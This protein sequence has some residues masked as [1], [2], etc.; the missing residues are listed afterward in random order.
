MTLN[1]IVKIAETA[2]SGQYRHDGVTPYFEHPRSV[3]SLVEGEYAK[4]VAFLHDVIEDTDETE[5]SLLEKGVPK[6]VVDAVVILTKTGEDYFEYLRKVKT[7]QL[8]RKVKIVDM[9]SNLSDDPTKNQ[10][11]K[12]TT[13]LLFLLKGETISL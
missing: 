12:Y 6:V 5:E 1:D 10:I 3:A 7:N 11:K 13:G 2:H 9:I 4:M 8:A